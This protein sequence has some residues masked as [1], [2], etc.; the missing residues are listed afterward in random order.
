MLMRF[1]QGMLDLLAPARCAA[2]DGELALHEQGFCGG[3]CMLI[4]GAAHAGEDD[5]VACV[6]GGPL[7]DALQRL[8][9]S[10]ALHVAPALSA[11]FEPSLEELG[12]RVDLVTAVP[13]AP[14]RLRARGY[15]QS[16]LLAQQV[17]RALRVP[18]RPGALRRV[19]A[20][21][22]QVGHGREVRALQLHLAF[23]A[24]GVQARRV[25]VLDDV[26]TTGA[27]LSEARRA[28]RA[29]GAHRVITLALAQTPESS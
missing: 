18:F 27:T 5:L 1:V 19:R 28:L 12:G 14:A 10:G 17:A 7:A 9:Y 21:A 23:E 4:D 2:C 11:L 16:G 29:G 8:K 6:Y 25:L 22:A 20:G 24:V 13:L 15:N 3:C 26:R